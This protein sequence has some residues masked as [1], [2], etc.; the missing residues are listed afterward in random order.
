[1]SSQVWF[2]IFNI[3]VKGLNIIF[4]FAFVFEAETESTAALLKLSAYN[5]FETSEK[6]FR[7]DI[8]C[9]YSCAFLKEANSATYLLSGPA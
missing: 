2:Y 3:K 8:A 4:G 7:A 5:P 1:M 9:S 6:D